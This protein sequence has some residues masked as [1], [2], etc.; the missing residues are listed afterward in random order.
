[1]RPG[2]LVRGRVL[3]VA[4]PLP[5][6]RVN[7]YDQDL[8][9]RQTLGEVATNGEGEYI[10]RFK[11]ERKRRAEQSG[12]DLRVVVCDAAG[13]EL[14]TSEVRFNVGP[15]T[16]IDVLVA[17][18]ALPARS[19]YERLVAKVTPSLDDVPMFELTDADVEFLAADIG[20]D[21]QRIAWLSDSAKLS[22]VTGSAETRPQLQ[23]RDSG[24]LARAGLLAPEVFYGWLRQGLPADLDD[25][26]TTDDQT[27]RLALERSQRE[28]VI[29][30][31]RD[32]ALDA[33]L[34]SMHALRV[35]RVLSPRRPERRP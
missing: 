25:L 3:T 11:P 22:R 1:V 14:G 2:F 6:A 16:V 18:A 9:G 5:D 23:V 8:R 24:H 35:S 31:L 32:G 4:G 10:L 26:I 21:R 34:A 30:S 13:D 33:I 29:P 12:P 27:L 20:A 19:E 17:N 28:N 15:E 7:V